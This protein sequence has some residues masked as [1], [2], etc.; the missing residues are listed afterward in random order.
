M[1]NS[2]QDSAGRTIK[3]FILAGQSNMVGAGI[4]HE[5]P[6]ALATPPAQ[7]RLIEDG[8]EK[9]LLWRPRFGPEVG[10]AHAIA[11]A[12]PGDPIILCKVARGGANL[13][14]DW[15]PDGCSRGAED[16]Y[17]GPLYPKLIEAVRQLKTAYNTSERPVRL[18][19][20]CWMQGERDSVFEFM[21]R[22]YARNLAAF[23]AAVRRDTGE[24]HL[25]CVL[26]AVAS[27]VY[28]L[29]EGRF[30]HAFKDI[31]REAQR[32][33]ARQDPLVALVETM[34]LPQNDN[35]HFDT[36]GQILLGQRYARSLVELASRSDIP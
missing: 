24:S 4:S 31:V 19:G 15:N 3:A 10:F 11:R 27:R 32:D 29:A 16:E 9:P 25:P 30:Q 12:F 28:R 33:V 23:L 6:A 14:Y 21:A 34:D 17:R 26:G 36:S 22:A 8:Q 35:L 7:V 2:S 18:C 20:L 1:S 13:F 5:L